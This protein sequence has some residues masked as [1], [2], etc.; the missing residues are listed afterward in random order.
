MISVEE[1]SQAILDE[2]Y[3][4]IDLPDVAIAKSAIKSIGEIC[5][6]LGRLKNNYLVKLLK[7]DNLNPLLISEVVK[8]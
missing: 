5:I 2:L 6:K 7:R 3:N 1:N 8:S 4:Y